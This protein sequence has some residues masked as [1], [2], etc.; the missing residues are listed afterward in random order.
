MKPFSTFQ[1]ILRQT[2]TIVMLVGVCC[3]H[4]LANGPARSKPARSITG[5]VT[6]G[7]NNQPIA[8]VNVLIKGTQIGTVT[9]KSGNYSITVNNDN[10]VLVYSFI[11]YKTQE[12]AV[13]NKSVIDVA[14]VENN[15][16]LG[17]VVV[18]ALGIKREA[19]SLGYSVGEV[20]GKD[21]SRVA[22]ENV[23]NSLAGRVAGVQISS[24][25]PSGS[26]VSMIIRGAKS[27][28]TD[29]QPLFVVDGVP[30]AN[31]L[32][33]VSQIGNDNRV[34]YGNAISDINPDDVENISIL[35]GPSAAALYGSRAGNGVVL[36]T[37][38][39][40]SKSQKMTVSVT[41]NTVFDQPY[42]YLKMSSQF[43]TGILPFTPDNNPY[44]GGILQIDESSSGGVGPE[45]DKGY[46]AIQWNSPVGS[47]GKQIP[48][49]LVSHPNNVRDFVRTG[50]TST[51]GVSIS[52]NS[53]KVTYRLSYSNMTSRGIIPNSDLFKNTLALNT[54]VRVSNKLT[55]STN[56]DFSRNNSN[57]RP[58]GERGTNPMQWAY[59]VGSHIDINDLRDYWVP[60]KEG[61]QQKSQSIGNYNNPYFLAY[62]VNNSYV[63]DRVFGNL[64][65]EWQLT[66]EIKLMGRYSLDT[67]SEQRETK[68]AKSYTGEPNGAYGLIN[69]KRYERNADFL[70]TYTK[71]FN[72]LSVVVS[73]GGNNRYSQSTDLSNSSKNGAGLII[74][75]LYTIQNIAPNNLQYNNYLYKKAIY[76][77]Y[78]TANLGF[79]DMIYLDL[80]ARNDWSS[81]LPVN[82]RSYF[83]P[84]A[85]V[86]LLLNEMFHI[87]NNVDLFK[88]RAG[89][90]QVGNDANPY[91]LYPTLGDAGAWNGVTRLSKS[92][93]ILLPELKPE[94]ATSY[95]VGID[96]NMFRNRLRFSGTYY[97]SENR[98][99]IL[100][101]Q[102]APSS[103][104][105]TKNINAGLLESRGV[106]LSLG[107]T[108]LDKG[109]LRWDLTTN[110]TKNTTRI[111]ELAEGIPYYTL[112]TD[113]KGGAW[114]YVGDKVGDIYD[115]AVIT[116]TDQKSPYYGYPILDN[117][118]SW[119]STSATNTKNK[120]GNFNPNFILGAQSSLSYKGF[121]LN[122]SLDWRSGGDFVSQ[123]Y[124]Y[125]ESDLRSQRFLDNLINPGGR[126]GD[127]LRNWLV[128]NQDEYIKI[129]GNFFPIVGGPTAAYGGYPFEF[130]GK[131]YAYGVFNPGVIAQYDSQGNITGYT[132]NLGGSGTKIIPYGDN[133][134]WSFTRAAT[135]DASFVKLREISLGYDIPAKFVKSI[136]LQNATFSVYSRNIILWT[137]AKINVD[138][139]MAFQPQSSPQAGTQFKQ[140]IERYNVTPWTIPVGFKLGLTF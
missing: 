140:G 125:M 41:S 60:G 132:E 113:A 131:T 138:P 139:E 10:A 78:A 85:S 31:S 71:R 9:D 101:S 13:G 38:K 1:F 136:G 29:N 69:L 137:A 83:Y 88:V 91:S 80:T 126:S 20:Q 43:A 44:P 7:T 129:H 96:Y 2:L 12:I 8:G 28:N 73:A 23:L 54:T 51:N 86:S 37:T 66:P 52:N 112:W 102:I 75:G 40:G 21:L 107:G 100:P 22:Q 36:I 16:V 45:L 99:Q 32:N 84:S 114:T 35:K 118:G 116:V 25:G 57:N 111:K 61:L 11:G 93:S 14:L 50:I 97:M 33:N 27:L 122:L 68:I 70:A 56:L 106:E 127:E 65:A 55:L 62:E 128:A 87:S 30:V 105:T 120:I 76:S 130:G 104:F 18:T 46:K 95:E 134:P 26:S 89:V 92:G 117:D 19:R 135:F 34:D 77:A 109:G 63:R 48:T 90:A 121:T 115:A 67:Y 108:I 49:P 58:A 4:A 110:F 24:T 3:M 15:E 59:A 42:K 79:K 82:N 133:Y 74:P 94:I 81:T 98:N 64:R 124:R 39:S 5:N 53:E 6:L 47:D 17:E 123:T 119:Q 72:A 103:G